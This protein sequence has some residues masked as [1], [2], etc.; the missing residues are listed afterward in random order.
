MPCRNTGQAVATTLFD[1]GHGLKG[2]ARRVVEAMLAWQERAVARHDLEQLDDERQR[3][4]SLTRAEVA[5]A[6]QSHAILEWRF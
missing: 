1:P 3:D 2:L 5:R 6:A 4:I